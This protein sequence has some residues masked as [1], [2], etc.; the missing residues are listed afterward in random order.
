M[1]DI[2]VAILATLATL[3]RVFITIGASIVTGWLLGY[4]AIKNKIFENIYISISE[5]LESVP[6]ITFFPV[7]LI[8]FVFEIGGS[9]GVELAVLFLVFTAVVWN[10][11]MGIY[12]A[13]KTIPEN[14][15]EVSENY[16]LGFLDKMT[17]LYI[18][19]S[20]PRIAANLIPSFADALFYISVSEVFSVGVH[21]YQVFGIGTLISNYTALGEYTYALYSLLILAI[22][23]TSITLFLREFA[24]FSVQ[25]YGLDTE[26]KENTMMRRGRFRVGYSARLGS[27]RGTFTKLAKYV[28]RPRPIDIDEEEN[29]KKLPWGKLGAGI[30]FLF[31]FLLAYSAF[32]AVKNVPISTWN[33]LISTIPQDLVQIGV[34]YIRVAIIALIS[35]IIA[36]FAGYYLAKDHRAERIAIP[37]IQSIAAFPAPAYFPLLFGATYPFLSKILGGYTDEVYVLLLGFVSTFYYIFYSYWLGVKNMPSEYW[38]VMDNLQMGFWQRLRKVVI[39]SAFPY[40][41]AGISSTVNSA[42]G[43][44]AIGEYW[45]QIYNNYN[46]E[47]KTGLMKELALAD[48]NGQLALVGWLSLIFAVIVVIYSIFFTR[49]LLDLARKKYVAEEGIYAA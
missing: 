31:L 23:T 6:V 13:F 43:G 34:D 9:L 11:W 24:A 46:L 12:Q 47:V 29:K 16:K 48:A 42:W 41:I 10:M 33:Y 21:T 8:F 32:I 22:F 30:G 35:F 36:I 20:I 39:P 26:S 5:V 14:L 45:P 7:V 2:V 18:P 40:I 28:T 25:R 27:A 19:Y 38:E 4:G 15:L 3:A 17:K 44:L 49:K 1:F 37:V